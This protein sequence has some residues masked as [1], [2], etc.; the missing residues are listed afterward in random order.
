MT[1]SIDRSQFL[2]AAIPAA[3]F[4]C[5]FTYESG[6]YSFLGVPPE[7]LEIPIS[8]MPVL[9]TGMAL[10]ISM[11]L[12][13]AFFSFHLQKSDTKIIRWLGHFL[14]LFLLFGAIPFLVN[15]TWVGLIF[16]AV[17]IAG[18]TIDPRNRSGTPE[19]K[20]A[21]DT[22]NLSE[23]QYAM[24]QIGLTIFMFIF[25][26][27]TLAGAGWCLQSKSESYLVLDGLPSHVIVGAYS[28]NFIAKQYDQKTLHLKSGVFLLPI[29]SERTK[30]IR[31]VHI[32]LLSHD[33]I[34]S[35]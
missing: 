4:F 9:L 20:A 6:R 32:R 14:L 31:Q 24:R 19:N 34:T 18:L 7:F 2:L 27:I 3:S 17:V 11:W 10:F 29:T 8:R 1:T 35:G 15:P 5:M 21:V 12:I 26:S 23:N 13:A 22:S 30:L 16:A 25:F 33:K 28:G